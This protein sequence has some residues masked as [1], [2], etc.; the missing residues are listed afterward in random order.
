M[1]YVYE[2]VAELDKNPGC[3]WDDP[4]FGP[5]ADDPHGSKSMYFAENDIPEGSPHPKEC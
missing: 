5:I 1:R 4:E 2:V 3:K